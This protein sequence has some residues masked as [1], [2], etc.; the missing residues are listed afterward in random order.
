MK[1]N[2]KNVVFGGKRPVNNRAKYEVQNNEN[3]KRQI[4]RRRKKEGADITA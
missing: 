2:N 1:S 3:R 4:D